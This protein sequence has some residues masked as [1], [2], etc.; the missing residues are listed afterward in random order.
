MDAEASTLRL[1]LAFLV[2]LHTG[3]LY[4]T[5][6]RASGD[7]GKWRSCSSS[8]LS[9]CTICVGLQLSLS[10]VCYPQGHKASVRNSAVTLQAVRPWWQAGGHN[11]RP[12]FHALTASSP[13]V[14]Y[15]LQVGHTPVFLC[16]RVCLC[17]RKLDHASNGKPCLGLA[18]SV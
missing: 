5:E 17:V 12:C 7:H 13:P 11:R 15:A 9:S 14:C 4:C 6:S 18:N 10:P 8:A 2:L 1:K 16:V 3:W